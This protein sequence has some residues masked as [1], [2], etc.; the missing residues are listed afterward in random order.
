MDKVII[1]FDNF[2]TNFNKT[3]IEVINKTIKNKF[4]LKVV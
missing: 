1:N 4:I 2:G 3:D